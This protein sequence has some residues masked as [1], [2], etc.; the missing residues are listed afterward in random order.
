MY[1][2]FINSNLLTIYKA[3]ELFKDKQK[4]YCAAWNWIK[5]MLWFNA[6]FYQA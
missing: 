3:F 6:E 2:Y 5:L 1:F 4:S